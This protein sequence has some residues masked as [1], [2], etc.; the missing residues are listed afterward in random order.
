LL[1]NHHQVKRETFFFSQI[2]QYFLG[3]DKTNTHQFISDRTYNDLD[4]DEL[5]MF[6]D[7][8]VSRVGQQYYYAIFRTIPA[9]EKRKNR[10]EGLIQLFKE[11]ALLKESVLEQLA[12]LKNPEAYFIASLIYDPYVQKPNWFWVV[13]LLSAVSIVSILLSFFFPQLLIFLLFVLIINYFIHYWNKRNLYQ[14]SG[15]ILQLLLLHRVAKQLLKAPEFANEAQE[16]RESVKSLDRIGNQMAFFK[17]ESKFQSELGLVFESIAEILKALLLIEPQLLFKALAALD[18]R[19]EQIRQI[20]QFVAELDVAISVASL[21]DGLA[22]CTPPTI[23]SAK[24]QLSATEIYHPLLENWVPN[25]I[26]LC[27]KSALL[28][29]SNMS[30]KT[31]F[32]RTLGINVIVGQTI[33]TCFA[34][35][36]TMPRLKIHSAI[37]IADDLMSEKSYYFE[38]VRVIKEMLD[39]SRSGAQNL[40]LLDELFKG[41]NTVERIAAGKSV[42]DYLN[43]SDNF[44]LVATH[45]L[46]L[47][48]YL[49]ETFQLYHFTEV[50]KGKTILFDYK[51]RKGNL[52]TTNAIRIL[53][54]NDYPDEIITNAQQL[55]EQFRAAKSRL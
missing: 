48:E 43:G 46:E 13:R 31:T 37:R 4:L 45:D 7:R 22:Y 39:E 27:E 41:T 52:E 25:S 3:S 54:L 26:D 35:E 49:S 16:L 24:K 15:S 47:T 51:I 20:Y 44:V 42:L 17:L 5:F 28:T 2:R 12:R 1:E 34:R 21:R 33:N 19:R 36:F 38:E 30:G 10:L 29:G 9:D 6:I 55:S 53:E 50:V 23:V 18:S 32:I 40:F 14:H 8:T 11:N